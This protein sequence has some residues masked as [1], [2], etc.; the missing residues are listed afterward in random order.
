MRFSPAKVTACVLAVLLLV[1]ATGAQ[2]GLIEQITIHGLFRMTRVA[3]LH[4]LGVREGDPY[5]PDLLRMRFRDLWDLGLFD[6]IVIQAEDAPGGGKHVVVTVKER[7]VLTSV[8]YEDNK[9]ANRTQIEDYLKE[10]EI[11]LQLGRPLDKKAIADAEAAIRDLLA[12]KGHLEG[13]V[14]YEIQDITVAS[15]AVY[16]KIRP[17]GKT[18]IHDIEFTGNTVFSDRKLK[19]QLQLTEERRWYWPYSQKNLYHPLKWDQDV[20][21]IRALYQNAG[22]LDVEIRAPVIEVRETREEPKA[23]GDESARTVEEPK[24]DAAPESDEPAPDLDAMTP[25]ERRKYAEREAKRREKERKKAEK[26][27][28]ESEPKVKKQLWLTVPIKEGPQYT[29]GEITVAGN[30]VFT[31]AQILALVPLR[32]GAVLRNGLLDR[33]V[34]GI[35]R[36]YEDRGHLYASVVRTIDRRENENVADIHISVEEE[37]PYYVSTIEFTGNTTTQDRV[38]RRELLLSEGALFNRTRLDVSKVKVNQLGY[39]EVT[40]DPIVEPIEGEN[41]VKVTFVGEEKGRNEIQV[42]GGY[43]GVDGA[44]FQGVYSTRNFLGRGQIVSL[45]LQIGGRSNRYQLSFQEPWF[46]NRPYTFGFSIFRRDVDF[47]A[48]LQ[49]SGTGFS[50]L[51]GKQ[52]G[53]F[54]RVTVG[55]SFENAESTTFS[56][57]GGNALVTSRT[58]ISSLTPTY[59]FDKINNP[60]RPTSGSQIIFSFQIAGGLLGGDTSF[61]K[62]V[63]RYTTYRKAFRKTRLAFHG[64]AGW[65]RDWAGGSD[66]VSASNINGVPRFQRFWLGGETIGPRVFETRSISPVRYLQL[67]EN[68][69]ISGA[70][71]DPSYY[72]NGT[73]VG[74]PV[75]TPIE[76]GGDRYYLAQTELVFSLNEQADIAAFLDIGDTLFEDQSLGI[77]TV[78]ASAGIEL[79][80]HLPVFPVPLRLIYGWPIRQG[81]LDRTSNFMFSIGRSF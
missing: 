5:D 52:V 69:R 55:Y 44:F 64:E 32:S 23:E 36:V 46:L 60:Y 7:P 30:S 10:R 56:L 57:T 12:Q 4:A 62:P 43:S 29:T 78:R 48:S 16:F 81:P 40:E 42:G 53:R 19:G 80:F 66:L 70:F 35:T 72:P 18:R 51:L 75:A 33:A 28:R 8:S 31:D 17:G 41:R 37:E 25:D 47:G 34:E 11:R 9:V 14:E 65:V 79:R 1:P 24:A 21:N 59:V 76:V 6:D 74:E 68:G 26:E 71:S 13:T 15:K 22:Y 27:D 63:F 38:L 77:D 3:F 2:S 73:I 54:A 67:D 50:V 49:N 61:L 58:A 45:A 20:S 39:F